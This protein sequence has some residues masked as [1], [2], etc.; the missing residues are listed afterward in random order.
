MI[1]ID[2]RLKNFSRSRIAHMRT[3]CIWN[4][5]GQVTHNRV[6][7]VFRTPLRIFFWCWRVFCKNGIF[8]A[9]CFKSNLPVFN[10]LLEIFPPLFWRC[11]IDII[12]N[13]LDG[14][15]KFTTFKFFNVF[16]RN[17]QSPAIEVSNSFTLL[18]I[19]A[20]VHL[21]TCKPSNSLIKI[22]TP[23]LLFWQ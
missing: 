16:W 5:R 19:E 21:T 15:Y 10:P 23:H 2:V 22:S 1:P 3:I 14:L 6:T 7:N 9:S 12:H 8:K 20:I 13:G 11:P 4:G 18:N 17:F